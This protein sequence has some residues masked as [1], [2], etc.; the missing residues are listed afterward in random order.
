M[1][2]FSAKARNRYRTILQVAWPLIVSN[3]F[4]NVQLTVDRVFLGNFSTEALAAAIAVSG[5]FWAPMAL[6][7]QTASYLMTFVAQYF[8]AK[9]HQM[10]GPATWQ[11]LHVSVIG[12]LLFLG[13]IPLSQLIF[14]VVGHSPELRTMEIAY[15]DALCYSALP[16]AVV[17]AVSSFF[18]GLG[19]T[20]VILWIN[21]IGMAA[22][23]F[24]A[25]VLIFG[26]WGFPALG[27]AGAGYA[28][29]LAG[30]VAAAFAVS[31]LFRQQFER[32]FRMISG[33][34][35]DFALIKRFLRY[36]LPSGMQWALEGLAFSVFLIIVGRMKDGQAALA[37]S[38]IVVTVMMLSV[39][40]AMGVAQAVA[41]QVGQ[42]LGERKGEEAKA[43][44][45]CGIHLA[46]AYMMSMGLSFVL[47]PHF[48]LGWFQNPSNLALWNDVARIVPVL[49]MFVAVF[50]CFD[51][52]N[53]VCSFT[54]KGAGDTR[55]V[56]AVALALPWPLMV[57]PTWIAREWDG[58]LYWAWGTASIYAMVQAMIFLRRFQSGKWI[59]M[60]VIH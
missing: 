49:L 54:L 60:S 52:L 16:T 25:Y 7:Q 56:S 14:A 5:I 43:V 1:T 26:K 19:R 39:L 45:W 50:T 32:E 20:R 30:Y 21:F 18:S 55:F 12:G 42:L 31:L 40:P 13:L 34:R 44:T 48:Y 46:L 10:I 41:I 58:A 24:F 2:P 8:G 28:T 11:A 51:S 38:G 53:L 4:W 23:A 36:G 6:L 33:W 57:L 17:A 3:S 37:G 15:F 47:V 35:P 29:A 59:T 22:N 9:E 27:V